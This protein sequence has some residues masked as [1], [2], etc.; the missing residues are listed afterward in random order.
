MD[1]YP[2]ALRSAWA[3][4]YARKCSAVWRCVDARRTLAY[5]CLAGDRA[6]ITRAQEALDRAVVEKDALLAQCLAAHDALREAE[7]AFYGVV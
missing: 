7:R 6:G 2:Q 5:A 1:A 4:L 3:D